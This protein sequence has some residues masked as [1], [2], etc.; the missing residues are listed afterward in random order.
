MQT[1]YVV[2][3][4]KEYE[5]MVAAL[6]L[7]KALADG[8][9]SAEQGGWLSAA[10]VRKKYALYEHK[11]CT[12]EEAAECRNCL[13]NRMKSI[14]CEL[15]VER[16]MA[17]TS[18]SGCLGW[19]RSVLEAAGRAHKQVVVDVYRTG[20]TWRPSENDAYLRAAG[21]LDY[22]RAERQAEL[23]EAEK[24]KNKQMDLFGG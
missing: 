7:Q 13:E 18:V 11:I 6:K 5:R 17:P 2:V 9:H 23:A 1:I 16:E 10:D 8:E 15:A 3:D 24:R 4:I 20:W 12:G 22:L 21:R 19:I 14:G